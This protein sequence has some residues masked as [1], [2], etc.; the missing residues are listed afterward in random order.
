MQ[1]V[2]NV[3]AAGV[4]ERRTMLAAMGLQ[5][6]YDVGLADDLHDLM[7]Q[8]PALLKE[9]VIICPIGTKPQRTGDKNNS[10]RPPKK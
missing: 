8:G 6:A 5:V 2:I 3:T 1:M 9:K 4:T 10:K 7:A